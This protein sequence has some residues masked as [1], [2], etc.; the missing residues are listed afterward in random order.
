MRYAWPWRAC[1]AAGGAALGAVELAV[2]LARHYPSPDGLT[3]LFAAIFVALVA[4]V[5]VLTW[6]LLAPGWRQLGWRSLA[7][8][9]VLTPC[10]ILW[11]AS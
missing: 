3:R 10:V 9:V 2:T 1:V 11:G 7:W 8:L 4:C 6:A 5:S